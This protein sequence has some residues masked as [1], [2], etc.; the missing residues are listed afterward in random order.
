[1]S[2]PIGRHDSAL[3]ILFYAAVSGLFAAA[4][5]SFANF[6]NAGLRG[7]EF[8]GDKLVLEGL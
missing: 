1:M 7:A 6:T 2:R 3:T 8:R 4:T 5:A